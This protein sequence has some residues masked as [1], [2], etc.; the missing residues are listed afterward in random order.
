LPVLGVPGWCSANMV[1]DFYRD[2]SVFRAGKP[3]ALYVITP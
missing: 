2:A 1:P 3:Q